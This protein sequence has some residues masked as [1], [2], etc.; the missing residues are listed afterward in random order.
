M[1][2]P[3]LVAEPRITST[4]IA[5]FVVLLEDVLNP[6]YGMEIAKAASLSHT[7]IYDTLA[8]LEA[9]RWLSSEWETLAAHEDARPRR[10]LYRLTPLGEVTARRAV[11]EHVRTLARVHS[12]LGWAPQPSGA[13]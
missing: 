6:R 8:R 13:S 3:G 4:V 9:A 2:Y 1:W 5:V 10:R 7:T 11:E 12:G